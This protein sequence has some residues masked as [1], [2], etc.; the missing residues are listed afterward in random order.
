MQMA[1]EPLIRDI[2][3]RVMG[4]ESRHVGFGVIAL[5]NV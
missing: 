4:D 5:E 3:G 2:V 1:D